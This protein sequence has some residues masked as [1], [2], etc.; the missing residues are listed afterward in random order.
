MRMLVTVTIPTEE[1]NEAIRDGSLP[2]IFEEILSDIKPEA[3]YFGLSLGN[4]ALYFVVNVTDGSQIPVIAAP[5]FLALNATI[6]AVPVFNLD[7]LQ[8]AFPQTQA[9][10]QKYR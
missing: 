1:G 4:R 6:E 8:K 2:K 9:I 3:L 10:A 7:E 5:F